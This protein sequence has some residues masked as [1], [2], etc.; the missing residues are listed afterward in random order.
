MNLEDKDHN[1]SH[2]IAYTTKIVS[3]YL[4]NNQ[5]NK[6]E[7]TDLIKTIHAELLQ[8]ENNPIKMNYQP[9][10][11]DPDESIHDDYLVCLEDGKKMIMLKRYLKT[12]YDLTPEEYRSK[13]NLPAN[14]PMVCKKYSERRSRVAMKHGLGKS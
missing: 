7:I 1:T 8:L 9:P 10:A 4:N 5:V 2:L 12:Q 3:S 14:Y 11:V 6:E 13:W